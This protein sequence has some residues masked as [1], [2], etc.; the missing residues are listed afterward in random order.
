M[1][2]VKRFMNTTNGWAHISAAV[3]ANGAELE[4]LAAPRAKLDGFRNQAEELYTEQSALTAGKQEAT[5]QLQEVL[6]AGNA[7]VDF[8]RT[9]VREH[10]GASS[11]K[12]V[13]FG[14]QPFRG[15]TRKTSLQP[16]D[17]PEPEPDPIEIVSPA[18]T[19][20]TVQ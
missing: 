6:R 20:D 7:L 10:Y 19:P 1:A 2:S 9:G 8:L 18:S 16:P 5:K 13:E 15:R 17:K 3:E 12:L 4:H 14:I 11:E